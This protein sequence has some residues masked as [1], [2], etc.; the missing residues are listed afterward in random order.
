MRAATR[1]SLPRQAAPATPVAVAA[2]AR[3]GGGREDQEEGGGIA[4]MR[5]PGGVDPAQVQEFI[6]NLPP[7]ARAMVEEMRR[8]RSE[9]FEELRS[10]RAS[11]QNDRAAPRS[12]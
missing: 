10:S 4:R 2:G 1:W 12:R 3:P 7:E 9:R 11:G 5:G 8:R 6:R